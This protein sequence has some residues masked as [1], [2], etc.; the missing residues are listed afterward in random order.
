MGC[1]WLFACVQAP[2]RPGVFPNCW[3]VSVL[4]KVRVS[5]RLSL[6]AVQRM[7]SITQWLELL[8]VLSLLLGVASLRLS[9][10]KRSL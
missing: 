1:L 4:G 10:L 9:L 6:D 3:T 7:C 8:I 2:E 5:R